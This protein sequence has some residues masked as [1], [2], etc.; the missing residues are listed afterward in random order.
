MKIAP[1]NFN[2]RQDTST[3]SSGV[4]ILPIC[5]SVKFKL[6]INLKMAKALGL[7]VTPMLLARPGVIDSR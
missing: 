7:S 2:R 5:R 3:A 1:N 6:L 4:P